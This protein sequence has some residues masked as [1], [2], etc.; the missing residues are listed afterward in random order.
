M[1]LHFGDLALY[2]YPMRSLGNYILLLLK[3]F[4]LIFF[5]FDASTFC[6]FSGAEYGQISSLDDAHVVKVWFVRLYG[7]RHEPYILL[8]LI[9][10]VCI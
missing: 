5:Q 4:E 10:P 1:K 7:K 9:A 6:G 8:L 2:C 3:H